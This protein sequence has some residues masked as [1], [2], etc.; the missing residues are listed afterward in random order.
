MRRKLRV[1]GRGEVREAEG[2]GVMWGL[3]DNFD[4]FHSDKGSQWKPLEDLNR[5]VI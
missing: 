1:R 2:H 5:G 3:V 4:D